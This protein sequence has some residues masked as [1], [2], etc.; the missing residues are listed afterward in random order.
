MERPPKYNHH[1][2][3][4]F[5]HTI[6]W[7][8]NRVVRVMIGFNSSSAPDRGFN[9]RLGQTLANMKLLG[10]MIMCTRGTTC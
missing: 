3:N 7:Y 5:F 9:P 1:I 2:L 8:L 6:Y 10:I 4:L